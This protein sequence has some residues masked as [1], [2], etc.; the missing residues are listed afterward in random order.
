MTCAEAADL[1]E[2]VAAGDTL[3][4]GE[5]AVHLSGCQACAAALDAAIRIER[6]LAARPAPAAPHG[7]AAQA[8]AAI[9][10]ERWR[11]EE[12][13]D[14]AF[15]V[16]IVAALVVVTVA[17]VSL[18]NLGSLA[19]MALVAIDTLSQIPRQS[20]GWQGAPPLPTLGLSMAAA[21]LA[22]GVWWWAERRSGQEAE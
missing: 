20:P 5:L 9:R 10:R 19:Q 22:L 4:D 13:V 11:S 1:I 21:T 15:N 12:R 3:P 17:I 14:R 8:L 7:F 2:A 18:F 16:T 6:A